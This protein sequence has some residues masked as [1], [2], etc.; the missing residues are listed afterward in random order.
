MTILEAENRKLRRRMRELEMELRRSKET[1]AR[2]LQE[3]EQLKGRIEVLE[4]LLKPG[5]DERI[6]ER[7]GAAFRQARVGYGSTSGRPLGSPRR[8]P[9]PLDLAW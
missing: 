9:Q 1:Q 6:H 7:V 5:S 8:I 3:N 4:R 2:V